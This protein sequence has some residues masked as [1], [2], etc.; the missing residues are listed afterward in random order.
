MTM[1][2]LAHSVFGFCDNC[3][4]CQFQTTPD[5]VMFALVAGGFVSAAK[6]FRTRVRKKRKKE[7]ESDFFRPFTDTVHT[8]TLSRVCG[9]TGSVSS[10]RE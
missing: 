6:A 8:A 2:A 4:L 5:S 1:D 10:S 3:A 7:R 9:E